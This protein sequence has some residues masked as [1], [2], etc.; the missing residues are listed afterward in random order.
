MK[1]RYYS[2]LIAARRTRWAAVEWANKHE[3]AIVNF[4]T[5]IAMLFVGSLLLLILGMIL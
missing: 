1:R 3:D 2:L 5:T 4:W